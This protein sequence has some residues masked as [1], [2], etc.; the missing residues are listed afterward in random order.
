[1][2]CVF[3]VS[4]PALCVMIV[5]CVPRKSRS[6]TGLQSFQT[7]HYQKMS[8]RS[9]SRGQDISGK[10]TL[11]LRSLLRCSQHCWAV[12]KVLPHCTGGCPLHIDT[13]C[14]PFYLRP[15]VYCVTPQCEYKT[16]SQVCSFSLEAAN[17][18]F[19]GLHRAQF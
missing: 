7:V 5:L 15:F 1:M 18:E 4:C 8:K 10:H 6:V 19:A 13:K 11:K 2:R 14:I 3:T 12:D 17:F 16:L 9:S